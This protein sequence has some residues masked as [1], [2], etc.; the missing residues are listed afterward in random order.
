MIGSRQNSARRV[1]AL[2]LAFAMLLGMAPS[3][4]AAEGRRSYTGVIDGA[5]YR[6]EM[7]ERWNGT[8]LL[9]SHGYYPVGFP[10]EDVGLTSHPTSEAR[11]LEDGYAL[12]ASNFKGV[13]GAV[14]DQALLDQTALLDWFDANVGRPEHTVAFG[15]SMGGALSVTL[16][17]RLAR[18]IDGVAPLCGPLDLNGTWNSVL[19]MNF[20][21]KTLL[22]PGENI[23]LV[24][25]TDAAGSVAKLA[26]AVQDALATPLGRARLALVAS[27]GNVPGWIS[28]A[29][30][31]PTDLV[32]QITAQAFLLQ[33]LAVDPFGP[34]GRVDLERRAGGNPSFNTGVDYGRQLAGSAERGLVFQ[35]Y[36]QPGVDLRDLGADLGVLA[37]APRISADPAA[38]KWLERYGVPRGTTPSPVLTLHNVADGAEVGHERWY[39]DRVREHGDPGRL[40][41]LYADRAGHCAFTAA[42]EIVVLRKLSE[43][44]ETG[45]WPGLDAR[46]LNAEAAEF[47]PGFQTSFDFETF[48][49]VTVQP[50]FTRFTPSMSSRPSR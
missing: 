25:P 29:K 36:R 43:R 47:G 41:Q 24:R 28:A 42:E 13:N 14:Y 45:R 40:R 46:R 27:F 37:K 39:A 30:P 1:A 23:E 3:A 2:L 26:K 5:K 12:A 16:A 49:Y 4:G 33:N 15:S 20:A 31:R 44:I 50:E 22:A 32:E 6:V 48:N 8:L 9:Y 35:A 18:R 19:D 38:R 21:I 7:P 17:E 11:L 10:I 34:R